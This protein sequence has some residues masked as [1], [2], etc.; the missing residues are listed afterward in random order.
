MRKYKL[1]IS[2]REFEAEILEI[3]TETA[4]VVV[5]GQEYTVELKELGRKPISMAPA[6]TPASQPPAASKS[7][8]TTAPAAPRSDG[9]SQSVKAPLPGL[10]VDIMVNENDAVKAGQ[11]LLLMEAMKMENQIPAPYDGT[12][13][14]I[15]V[16]KGDSVSEGD[17]LIEISR[18]PMTTL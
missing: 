3:T 18:P 4:R 2:G 10:I 17:V 11:N 6:P 9:D 15:H 8:R 7:Q 5:D 1:A 12:V 14:R 13:K 16:K